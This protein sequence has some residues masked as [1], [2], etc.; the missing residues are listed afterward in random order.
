MNMPGM[1]QTTV[2]RAFLSIS[3]MRD[4]QRYHIFE[5]GDS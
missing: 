5:S 3:K 1:S 4:M 2:Y